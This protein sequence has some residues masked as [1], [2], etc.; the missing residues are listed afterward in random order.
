MIWALVGV[1]V[2][3]GHTGHFNTV[4]AAQGPL[5][6]PANPYLIRI[7]IRQPVLTVYKNGRSIRSYPVVLGR[8][9]TQT[10]VGNWRIID[11]QKN[12]GDGFGSRWLAL[13]VPWGIYGIHGTNRPEYIGTYASNGCIRMRN[14]DVEQL[15]DLVPK[16]TPVNI[17]GDPLRY[18]RTLRYGNIGA[19]VQLVQQRLK[20]LGYFRG[21]CDGR[22]G[23]VMEFGLIYYELSER[24]P[25]DGEVGMDDYRTLGLIQIH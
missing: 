18:I 19:D 20:E 25:M 15:Y 3:V 9:E 24:L 17:L 2:L 7:D 10:P 8:P 16:G 11:K 14:V 12:W 22:F 23:P 5:T 1:G 6:E 13:N 4:M 21:E